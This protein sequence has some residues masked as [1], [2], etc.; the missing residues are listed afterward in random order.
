MARTRVYR[1]DWRT[2]T[3]HIQSNSKHRLF[4][5]QMTSLSS[6]LPYYAPM[7]RDTRNLNI[8][9]LQ[10]GF[11]LFLKYTKYIDSNI[12]TRYNHVPRQLFGHPALIMQTD[13]EEESVIICIVWT[14][15]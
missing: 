14:F 9:T 5:I 2:S 3:I 6:S 11:I 13:P 12:L 8:G 15:L 10:E 7:E 1:S 4:Y